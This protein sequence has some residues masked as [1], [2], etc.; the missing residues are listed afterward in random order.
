[1]AHDRMFQSNSAIDNKA[2]WY[3][4][5]Y[6]TVCMNKVSVA[7]DMEGNMGQV[8]TNKICKKIWMWQATGNTYKTSYQGK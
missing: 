2:R 4:S 6:D 1:M 7:R 5:E 8:V 3:M